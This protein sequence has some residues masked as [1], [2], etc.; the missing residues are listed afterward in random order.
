MFKSYKSNTRQRK[1]N[2]L[3]KEQRKR[4]CQQHDNST[5]I[6]LVCLV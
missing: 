5:K 4:L 1:I 2:E 3:L 6:L